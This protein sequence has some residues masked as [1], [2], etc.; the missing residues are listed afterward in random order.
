MYN[1]DLDSI[2]D[3]FPDG[4][5][6]KS[7]IVSSTKYSGI[8]LTDESSWDEI[9]AAF[10]EYF[11]QTYYLY[12]SGDT[13][14]SF[15]GG[16]SASGTYSSYSIDSDNKLYF[17]SFRQGTNQSE[18]YGYLKTV[19]SVPIEVGHTKLICHVT[20][21]NQFYGQLRFYVGTSP[22]AMSRYVPICGYNTD[23]TSSSSVS[24]RNFTIDISSLS[25]NYYVGFMIASGGGNNEN[26]TL[27]VDKIW[28][29]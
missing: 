10:K 13:C 22:T 25:G 15:T 24:N 14:S 11:P 26:A 9:I 8:G 2:K 16:Y 21:A 4:A 18:S 23:G 1:N 6:I 27:Y 17:Y 3:S 12:N 29:E 19:K 7:Q 28:I 5:T 20:S